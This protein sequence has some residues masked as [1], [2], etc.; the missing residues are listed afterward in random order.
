[1]AKDLEIASHELGLHEADPAAW[2]AAHRA[3]RCAAKKI[4]P[5]AVEARI[6]ERT[7]ARQQKDFARADSLRESLKNDSIEIMDT[8]AGTTWRV[9][10]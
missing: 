6:A 1:L 3:R 9:S 7:A 10:D 2:L 8:P 5:A 4:D